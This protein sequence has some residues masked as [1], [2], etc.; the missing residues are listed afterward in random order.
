MAPLRW[1]ILSAG[2]ISFDFAVGAV[3]ALPEAEHR[4]VAVAARNLD[5]ATEF[6][7]TFGIPKAFGTYE[8]LVKD[9]E[10]GEDFRYLKILTRNWQVLFNHC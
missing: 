5:S 3:S 8:E 1:G 6:A 7:K 9:K 10:I 4:L 2:K